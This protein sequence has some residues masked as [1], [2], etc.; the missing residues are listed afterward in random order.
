M[1]GFAFSITA[2]C[3]IAEAF[4]Q[5]CFCDLLFIYTKQS[6]SKLW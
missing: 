2:L 1:T 5:H 4:E 3:S 6:K